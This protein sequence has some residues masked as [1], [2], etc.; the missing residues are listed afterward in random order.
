MKVTNSTIE[1]ILGGSLVSIDEAAAHLML[2]ALAEDLKEAR[3][4]PR[5]IIRTPLITFPANVSAPVRISNVEQLRT[6]LPE[7]YATM[8]DERARVSALSAMSDPYPLM[9]IPR[10]NVWLLQLNDMR[11]DHPSALTAVGRASSMD[12]LNKFVARER[13]PEPYQDGEW[14]KHFKAGGPLEWFNPPAVAECFQ[15]VT[16]NMD[17]YIAHAYAALK[18]VENL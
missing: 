1:A 9:L 6:N 14:T 11:G 17:N 10:V 5:Q 8:V 2:K 18:A 7:P 15:N 13:A 3:E 4:T 16:E 12:A